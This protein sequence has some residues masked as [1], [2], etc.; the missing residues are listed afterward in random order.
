[1]CMCLGLT[2]QGW[3]EVIS[4]IAL[5]T[6][7]V[8]LY[9]ANNKSANAAK[10][11]AQLNKEIV[12]ISKETVRLNKETA[13]LNMS[14]HEKKFELNEREVVA[15]RFHI[16]RII[17]DRASQLHKAIEGTDA[18]RIVSKL[19]NIDEGNMDIIGGIE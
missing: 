16:G 9:I 13:E 2:I 8:L 7:T 1:M 10:E 4:S 6:F 12:E 5:A 3:V 11:T 18:K 14:I 19:N 17:Y 15:L